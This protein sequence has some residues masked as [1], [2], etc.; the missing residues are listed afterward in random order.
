[1]ATKRSTTLPPRLPP[2][3]ERSAVPWLLLVGLFTAAPH[4]EHLP[5]WLSLLALALL[6]WRAWL[7]RG[8]ARLPPRWILVL[9]VLLGVGGIVGE[10]HSLFGRDA[11]VALLFFFVA[12]KPMEMRSRR[13]A[14]VIVMLG[15]FL[16]LTHYFYSQS[17]PTGL[18]LLLSA[19]LLTAALIRLHGGAQTTGAI[20]RH[21]G[22][23]LAQALPFMV[24]LYLL[25]P[26]ISGPL[27]GL[28][29]DAYAGQS[30]L[31]ETMA[32]GSLSQLIQSGA[33]AFRVQFADRIPEK[34]TLYWRGP[35][36]DSYDGLTWRASVLPPNIKPVPPVIEALG[37]PVDYVSTLE[38]SNQ[39]W[40]LALDVPTSLPPDS[41]LSPLL[42]PLA[43]NP[44]HSR[45]HYAFSSTV[46]YVANRLETPFALQQALGLPARIN[47]R[48][49]TLAAEWR[50]QANSD[51]QIVSAA[52]AM[53]RREAF[54]YTLRPPLLG[55]HAM[56]EFLF[57]TRRG[58]CEHY[59]S[60]FVFLMRAAGVPARVVNGYQGGELNPVDG[61]FTVRQSDAHAWA[62]IW[63]A[64][65]GWVR[66][67]PTAAVA[68]SRVEQGIAAA[69]PESEPL[70][71]LLRLDAEWLRQVRNRWEAANNAWNQWVI[72]YNPQRQRELLSR[73]GFQ[74]PDWQSM[75]VTLT[76][77]CG[78]TLLLV[79]AWTLV[80]RRSDD[81]AQRAW[82]R[83]C[84]RLQRYGVVRAQ[85]EGPLEFAARVVRERPDLGVLTSQ[86][87]HCYADL[88]YGKIGRGDPAG[89]QRLRELQRCS[90]RLPLLW[91]KIV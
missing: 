58:F 24:I 90:R 55:K 1:M 7:W 56:D 43:T 18:W 21:A 47:P 79:T 84:A 8:N 20:F 3:L 77:L 13:D 63:L 83:Y 27:W 23:L 65:Q 39:R 53:F 61:F 52:L 41:T 42:Q 89:A 6:A 9:L 2:P 67:D 82:Q 4:A 48:T 26:R 51:E 37:P 19:T 73:L 11:G 25:F 76:A 35:V 71:L 86:A 14:L 87:A 50:A 15:Y 74:N 57:D 45:A 60:A 29:H 5:L 12:L 81:P 36:L 54:Y 80:Q 70:P 85:W 91:R 22:L 38:A 59:A 64:G 49:R 69:L 72:A 33:I 40:L 44:L 30:G 34:S 10:F 75:S 32:P 68:P 46:R 88:H 62:E 66:V 28:P 31:S 78:I 17:I 16:L